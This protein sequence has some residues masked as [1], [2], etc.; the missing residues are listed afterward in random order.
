MH[1]TNGKLPLQRNC[2]AAAAAAASSSS[3]CSAAISASTAA[4]S[5][6]SY[7]AGL[8]KEDKFFNQS[9]FTALG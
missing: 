8:A 4:V 5:R 6:G 1:E 7:H 9:L 2:S 3:T